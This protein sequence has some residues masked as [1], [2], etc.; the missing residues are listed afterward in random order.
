VL[1]RGKSPGLKNHEY[2]SL[3][4]GLGEYPKGIINV[5]IRPLPTVDIVCH[6]LYLPFKG[7]TKKGSL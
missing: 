6:A 5:D 1:E 4:I 7:E 3:D 2:L